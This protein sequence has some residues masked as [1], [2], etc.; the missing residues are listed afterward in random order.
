MFALALRGWKTS[1]SNGHM[2]WGIEKVG[3]SL[4]S[5]WAASLKP[6]ATPK[7]PT[8]VA[9]MQSRFIPDR[10]P[11]GGRRKTNQN[12]NW[13]IRHR[14]HNSCLEL[15]HTSLHGSRLQWW[16]RWLESLAGNVV[17]IQGETNMGQLVS[18]AFMR[19]FSHSSRHPCDASTVAVIL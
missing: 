18:H 5:R 14:T 16:T 2:A 17:S 4:H 9:E 12:E 11:F 8:L 7:T 10:T 1:V 19:H 15:S 3:Q 6:D 13:M